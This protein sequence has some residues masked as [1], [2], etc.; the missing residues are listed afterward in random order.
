MRSKEA[1][2]KCSIAHL[3]KVLVGPVK[4]KKLEN[5]VKFI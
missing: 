4:S 3:W 2:S 1:E 5:F